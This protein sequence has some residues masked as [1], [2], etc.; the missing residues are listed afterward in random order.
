MKQ[1]TIKTLGAAALGAAIAVTA[2]GAASA[3]EVSGVDTD[4]VLKS[5]PVKNTAKH[6]TKP[7]SGA[8]ST[9]VGN[10]KTPLNSQGNLLGGLPPTSTIAKAA[11]AL[12]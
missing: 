7:L 4:S 12:G 5:A 2:A 9:P 10:I 11:K 6:A 1:G 3:A 8:H